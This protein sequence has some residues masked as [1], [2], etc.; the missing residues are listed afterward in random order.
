MDPQVS[1]EAPGSLPLPTC[2]T[3]GPVGLVIRSLRTDTSVTKDEGSGTPVTRTACLSSVK[4]AD[5]EKRPEERIF[6]H[7]RV[8][9]GEQRGA[10]RSRAR[11]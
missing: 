6:A 5:E 3:A 9:E 11:C 7:G 10:R 8:S 2:S 4:G 1:W